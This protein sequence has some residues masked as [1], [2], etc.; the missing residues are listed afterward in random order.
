[1]FVKSTENILEV[2]EKS[3]LSKN[4]E[5]TKLKMWLEYS[6]KT[7]FFEKKLFSKGSRN[8]SMD[9]TSMFKVSEKFTELRP[10]V[11]KKS[12]TH[13]TPI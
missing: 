7:S 4:E 6:D 13:D 3:F 12:M 5:E 11:S 2:F 8:F 9:F 10:C 1:M